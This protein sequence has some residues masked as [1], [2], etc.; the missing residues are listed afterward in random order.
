MKK[1]FLSVLITGLFLLCVASMA[2]AA[3]TTI[4]TAGYDDGSGVVDYNLIWDDDN[5]GN[6]VVW[7]DY[8][9]AAT[10]WSAQNAWAAGLDSDLTYDID[11]AYTVDWDDAAWRLPSTVDGPWVDGCDGT[12]TA[13]FNIISSEMGHLYYE[14]LGNLGFYDTDGHWQPGWGLNNTGDFNNLI[15]NEYWSGT[16]YAE[17]SGAW[18]FKLLNGDQDPYCKN[19]QMYGLAVRSGQVSAVPVPAAIWLLG[20]GMAGLA[21]L[22]RRRKGNRV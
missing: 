13:G 20:S 5:N 11:A 19:F 22:G 15:K 10:N 4:G 17:M 1:K 6:S 2:N 3:L 16:E 9:N 14:E 8:S 21:A 7:L 12:T 18:S